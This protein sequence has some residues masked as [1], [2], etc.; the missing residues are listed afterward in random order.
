MNNEDR[1]EIEQQQHELNVFLHSVN[2]LMVAVQGL[3]T[4]V[5]KQDAEQIA[6]Q[7]GRLF[8]EHARIEALSADEEEEVSDDAPKLIL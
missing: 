7:M 8:A 1:L 2:R 3:K 4:A 5:E 6:R